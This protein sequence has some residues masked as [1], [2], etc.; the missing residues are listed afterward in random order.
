MHVNHTGTLTITHLQRTGALEG[1][2]WV[3]GALYHGLE[4]LGALHPRAIKRTP[5]SKRVGG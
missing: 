2:L 1:C 5:R 4:K 3:L